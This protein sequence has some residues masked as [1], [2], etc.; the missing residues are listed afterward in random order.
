MAVNFRKITDIDELLAWRRE[1]ICAVFGSEPSDSLMAAGRDYYR[2]ALKAGTHLAFIADC[3]GNEAGCGSICLSEELPSPDNPSGRC[4]YLMN[5]F[6]RGPYR[7]HG[8]GK[9]LVSRLIAEARRL[10]CGKIYLETTDMGRD[11]YRQLGFRP[12]PDMMKLEKI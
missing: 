3:D 2:R 7:R 6:V 1:V 12:M 9:A 11:V 10:N 5:I 8:V 4:A